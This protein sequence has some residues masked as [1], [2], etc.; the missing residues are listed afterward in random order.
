MKASPSSNGINIKLDIKPKIIE[1]KFVKFC[2]VLIRRNVQIL[3]PLGKL[4][5]P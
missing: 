4:L 5:I 2:E 3:I 1:L